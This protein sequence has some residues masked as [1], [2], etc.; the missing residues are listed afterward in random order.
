MI[1][2][3]ILWWLCFDDEEDDYDDH[4]NDHYDDYYDDNYDYFKSLGW[5]KLVLGGIIS[6]T[7]FLSGAL[8]LFTQIGRMMNG[9]SNT[10]L[11]TQVIHYHEKLYYCYLLLI[12]GYQVWTC[13]V[14]N[15]KPTESTTSVVGRH[16]SA[17]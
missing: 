9:I 13:M 5:I 6:K 10:C 15:W 11:D 7:V 17:S 1:M 16:C 3:M 4:Y 12:W 8:L 14:W 2:M